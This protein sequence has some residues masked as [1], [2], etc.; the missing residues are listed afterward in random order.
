MGLIQL[1]VVLIVIGILLWIVEQ[2]PF[3][4][5]SFKPVIRWVMIAVVVLW[6]LTVFVGDIPLPRFR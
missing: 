6:L 3:I 5:A 4:S 2:V 1:L